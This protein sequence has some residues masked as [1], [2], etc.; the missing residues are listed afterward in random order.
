MAVLHLLQPEQV[1]QFDFNLLFL[2]GVLLGFTLRPV[3]KPVYW[4]PSTSFAALL[5]LLLGLGP[6]GKALE[7]MVLGMPFDEVAQGLLLGELA[8]AIVLAGFAPFLL[9]PAQ[10]L[11]DWPRFGRRL[12]QGLFR[13]K[14]L[15]HLGICAVAYAA[16]FLCTQALAEAEWDVTQGLAELSKFLALPPTAPTEKIGLLLARGLL[17]TLVLL[18][19]CFT[20]TREP[21]E[22]WIVLGSLLFVVAEF[23]PAFVYFQQ[24]P[25]SLL[26]DQ[27]VAGF[28]RQ[29][30]FAGLVATLFHITPIATT[31]V[32][33]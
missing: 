8:A 25:P 32:A 5:C 6:V 21:F 10:R 31:K 17:I 2:A 4:K 26:I 14:S 28:L 23:T 33:N 18:P 22:L 16:L 30:L 24:V 13:W 29:G 7:G 20:L 15:A 3:V 27:V 1:A 19:I 11:L 12:R 9:A